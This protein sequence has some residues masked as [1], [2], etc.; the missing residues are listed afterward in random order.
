MMTRYPL[1]DPNAM[2]R[3]GLVILI[4]FNLCNYVF[5]SRQIF[6]EGVRDGFT[7]LLFGLAAGFLLLGLK[8][9]SRGQG[10]DDGRCA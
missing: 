3:L 10:S 7:G 1:K 9:Q 5:T 2:I 6:S 8:V 4:L